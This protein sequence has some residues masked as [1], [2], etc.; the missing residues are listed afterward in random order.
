MQTKWNL[1]GLV[2]CTNYIIVIARFTTPEITSTTMKQVKSIICNLANVLTL[3]VRWW[4]GC[5]LFLM[6]YN[7]SLF[8]A[9]LLRHGLSFCRLHCESQQ[10]V[11]KNIFGGLYGNT[12]FHVL[13]SPNRKL[14]YNICDTDGNNIVS[15]LLY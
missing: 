14:F 5:C 13:Y 10:A 11:Y 7:Y 12:S 1:K 15:L 3:L 2:Q 9:F 6:S 8:I 4:Q